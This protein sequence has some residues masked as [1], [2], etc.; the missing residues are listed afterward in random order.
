MD[1]IKISVI[2][3]LYHHEEQYV[4][5]CLDSLIE[6]TMKDIEFILIDNGADETNKKLIEEYKLK[7]SRFKSIHISKNIGMGAALN[8]GIYAAK[9]D[10]IGFLESDD[11]AK[12]NMYEDLYS[13]SNNGQIDIVKSLFNTLDTAGN[14]NLQNNF[15]AN[16][17]NIVLEGKG[18]CSGLIQGHVSH[19]SGIYKKQFLTKNHI[20]FNET[21]GGHSQDF[22]F[23]LLCYAFAQTVYILPY[24]YVTY[25]LFT[26]RH[27]IKFLNDCMLDECELTLKK[28][29]RRRVS[30]EVWEIIFLRVAPRLQSCLATSDKLQRKRIIKELTK[31]AK[32]QSYKYF[33]PVLKSSIKNLIKANSLKNKIKSSIIKK[34]KTETKSSVKLFGI[35]LKQQTQTITKIT[36]KYLRGLIKIEITNN[37]YSFYI[38]GIKLISKKDSDDK[39]YLKILGLPIYYKSLQFQIKTQQIQLLQQRLENIIQQLLE[40]KNI[41]NL[42]NQKI[43]NLKC[44][45]EAQTL[46]KDTFGPYK[47]AFKGKDVVLVCTGPTAKK[48]T[49]IA[50]AIH[51]GVNGAVYLE[52]VSL[53]YLFVQD[54]TIKQAENNTLINDIINYQGNNCKKFFGIIPDERLHIVKKYIERI[55]LHCS[56][57]KN[58]SQYIL[59]DLF[60]H[61]IAY[62]LSR[63][64]MGDFSGTPFSALQFILYTNPKR[65]YLVG[66]DCSSGYAYN[67]PNAI[68]PANYQITI[69]KQHFIPFIK[70]NYPHL[71]IISINPVGLKGVFNDLYK[72]I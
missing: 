20:T 55:P 7:D 32:M 68:N 46:H 69:L 58:I 22:G 3:S 35:K 9:G 24:A 72:G 4:R 21:P 12:H 38:L 53:D 39:K 41:H 51:I 31:D 23:M 44:I 47:N 52:N 48:Y 6:Q 28:L 2:T 42:M 61:N 57:N 56:Y 59:E 64:P 30:A 15:P 43:S 34:T 40:Q 26:G 71:E 70:L 49:P 8:K 13:H 14:I 37:H 60:M 33:S 18:K 62:D 45:I 29:R 63:D 27:D 36:T 19:W 66:W 25:R 10:Y 67:K 50:G 16:Q 1:N 54:Y 65:L 11:F 17:C 5:Q